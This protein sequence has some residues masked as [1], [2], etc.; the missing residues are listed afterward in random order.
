[1]KEN[2]FTQ[3]CWEEK[4]INLLIHVLWS[5]YGKQQQLT[6]KGCLCPQKTPK[7]GPKVNSR[8]P[9]VACNYCKY[10]II[11]SIAL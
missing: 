6:K 10:E 1:M 4:F 11:C 2:T 3:Y 7:P 8:G 5:A 9:G